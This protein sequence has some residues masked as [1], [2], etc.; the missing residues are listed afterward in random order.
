MFH[1]KGEWG[2]A[3]SPGAFP[4]F[5]YEKWEGLVREI[6]C[7]T[8]SYIMPQGPKVALSYRFERKVC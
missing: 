3:S 5:Q 8:P 6:T 1:L 4:A 7:V 2:V